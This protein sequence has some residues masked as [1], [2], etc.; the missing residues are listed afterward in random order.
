MRRLFLWLAATDHTLLNDC[1]ALRRS[2]EIRQAQLGAL[3]LVPVLMA[4]LSMSYAV[5]TLVDNPVV[6]F[7]AG[8]TFSYAIA[9]IDRYIVATVHRSTLPG[10]T[11][12]AVPGILA[13][14]AFAIVLG[15][16][17][18]HPL[19]L[20]V[21]D[22]SI[23]QRLRD[24]LQVAVTARLD[25]AAND[26][27][28]I[29]KQAQA[30]RAAVGGDRHA[31]RQLRRL[32]SR[33][34]CLN[35]LL[36]AE[37]SGARRR[38]PCGTSSGLAECRSRCQ[39]ILTRVRRLD[40]EIS[41]ASRLVR[42]SDR[43]IRNQIRQI[44][45]RTRAALA[46]IDK[47]ATAD[48]AAIE[49]TFSNDYNARRRALH[50]LEAEDPGVTR[51]KWWVMALFIVLDIT[52]ITMKVSS[53]GNEYDLRHDTAL[54]NARER[55][56]GEQQAARQRT[57]AAA[58]RLAEHEAEIHATVVLTESVRA[59]TRAQMNVSLAFEQ[60]IKDARA[61]A[62]DDAERDFLEPVI[63]K[64]RITMTD[65]FDRAAQQL[66]DVLRVPQPSNET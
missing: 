45:R 34:D 52:P 32:A 17:V 23:E 61:K 28:E 15:V 33:R 66:S 58:A 18:S 50:A 11:R 13:R 8:V 47:R 14:Y 60:D 6:Y 27:A 65:A 39:V 40:A 4:F 51:T 49:Q 53:K 19:V 35:E 24:D 31:V 43:D 3:L 62:R 56:I 26:K 21:F 1:G 64:A 20:L 44:D 22:E 10:A 30:D 63:S 59:A 16:I 46:G 54:V 7:S 29:R 38:L 5:S 41:Q 37:Q 25:Q 42:S 36:F 9:C 2:A 57:A 48:I 55:A 12:A